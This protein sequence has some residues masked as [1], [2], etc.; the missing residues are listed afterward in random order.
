MQFI[1]KPRGTG[2]TWDACWQ[3]HRYSATIL[4]ATH[5][6]EVYINRCK[7]IGI[8]PIPV[9]SVDDLIAGKFYSAYVVIDE[10]DIVLE[11]L[12]KVYGIVPILGI[13]SI[14]P[15]D[16]FNGGVR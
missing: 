13:M 4:T 16:K 10:V 12:L 6:K 8:P 7:E 3:A 11:Q 5:N 1:I 9:R 15:T 14:D 2:K